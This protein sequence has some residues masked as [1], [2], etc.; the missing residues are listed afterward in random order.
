M[1]KIIVEN[2]SIEGVRFTGEEPANFLILSEDD[3]FTVTK[4]IYYDFVASS[5]AEDVLIRGSAITTIEGQCGTCLKT[6]E[7]EVPC[8]DICC[9]YEDPGQGE[10]DIS[11]QFR[12]GISIHIPSGICCS[13]NC[14]GLCQTCGQ[15]LNDKKCGCEEQIIEIRPEKNIWGKLDDLDIDN[16]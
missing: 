9:Y 8:N 10:L 1:I 4:P 16:K 15:N 13:K 11:Q 7:V 12:E 3:P 5:A 2:L 14:N 6:C